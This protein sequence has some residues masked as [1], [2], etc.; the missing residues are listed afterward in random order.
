MAARLGPEGSYTCLQTLK[1]SSSGSDRSSWE[2]LLPASQ[3]ARKQKQRSG[4]LKRSSSEFAL[5]FVR[6]GLASSSS[7]SRI[8]AQINPAMLLLRLCLPEP[9]ET[10]RMTRTRTFTVEQQPKGGWSGGRRKTKEHKTT[11]MMVAPWRR[12]Q[13]QQDIN[14][15]QFE[16]KSKSVSRTIF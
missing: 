12:Q 10:R 4:L 5:T 14:R 7:S 11:K 3:P 1:H 2:K 9:E 6:L 8:A 15:R 13:Q 16:R